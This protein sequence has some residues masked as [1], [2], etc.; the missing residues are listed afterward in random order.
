MTVAYDTAPPTALIAVPVLLSTSGI[1][2]LPSISG[3]ATGN[4]SLS[5]VKIAIQNM[6]S[7]L[8]MDDT[9]N[10]GVGPTSTP[11]FIAVTY[12]SP[13]ATSWAYAPSGLASKFTGNTK[14][15]LVAQATAG[16]GLV[17][18]V[19]TVGVSSFIIVIDT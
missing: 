2:S 3:T 10:F 9:T 13:S 7:G 18:D 12:L 17:Q 19:Y 6:S 1:I 11:N 14:Y 8:W 5:N 16:S 4:L 15:V